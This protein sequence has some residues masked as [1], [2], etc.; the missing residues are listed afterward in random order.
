MYILDVMH[1]DFNILEAAAH[2]LEAPELVAE[3]ERARAKAEAGL[4][5]VAC[6]GQFKRGK[7]TLINALVGQD[8]APMGVTPITSAVTIVRAGTSNRG[9]VHF[10]DGRSLEIDLDDIQHYASEEMNPENE[11]KVAAIEVF[12]RSPILTRGLCLV[13]TPG[14]G[15]VFKGNTAVTLDFVP[16]IDAAIVVVGVD[17]PI[18][19]DEIALM[20]EIRRL[21][22]QIIVVINKVDKCSVED[23]RAAITFTKDIVERHNQIT[24]GTIHSVSALEVLREHRSTRGW[25]GLLQRLA[26]LLDANPAQHV[27]LRA[28]KLL[29]HR[30]LAEIRQQKIALT[31][32]LEES[33]ARFAAL[34]TELHE[35]RHSLANLKYLL[36]GEQ[37][38]LATRFVEL[39]EALATR[40]KP[41]I[42]DAVDEYLT[43]K[44]RVKRGAL[45]RFLIS[46]VQDTSEVHMEAAIPSLFH[47]AEALYASGIDSFF[48][49]AKVFL[50]SVAATGED[51]GSDLDGLFE[52]LARP[53]TFRTESRFYHHAQA[54]LAPASPLRSASDILLPKTLA[55]GRLRQEIL[56]FAGKLLSTNTTLLRNDLD[57]LVAE[58][59]RRVESEL[60]SVLKRVRDAASQRQVRVR[61][62]IAAGT[63]AIQE[64]LDVLEAA[65]CSI[66]AVNR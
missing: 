37:D 22:D 59:R 35:L 1:E 40:L 4:I 60:Q 50:A 10:R 58:S 16:H 18:T 15:S 54:H 26:S 9:M 32:P 65:Q 53:Q 45:R 44:D 20:T 17:P 64:R 25:D 33:E 5:Y 6:V 46:M 62:T 21:T 27:S 24:V 56:T 41:V 66:E 43:R 3:A 11:K 42:E 61:E 28:K 14:L 2:H 12:V 30:L 51:G 13:D 39:T 29:S 57:N 55:V 23:T 8:V 63:E 38:R 47:E 52:E 34:E 36:Q 49:T 19:G 31:S 7:S 48:Q